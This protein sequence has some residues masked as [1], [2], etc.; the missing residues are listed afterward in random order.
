MIERKLRIEIGTKL[1]NALV[2]E[3][4]SASKQDRKPQFSYQ[5][6]ELFITKLRRIE[7]TDF[8]EVTLSQYGVE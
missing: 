5:G 1:F 6:D 8:I 7:S 2:H 3:V 4:N